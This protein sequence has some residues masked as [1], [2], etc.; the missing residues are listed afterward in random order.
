MSKVDF[1]TKAVLDAIEGFDEGTVKEFARTVEN[2][3]RLYAGDKAK[4]K[5]AFRELTLNKSI[6]FETKRKEVFLNA[7]KQNQVIADIEAR[8]PENPTPEQVG[9]ELT[10]VLAAN[11]IDM[12]GNVGRSVEA[13]AKAMAN[14]ISSYVLKRLDDIGA[15]EVLRS[16]KY[17]IDILKEMHAMTMKGYDGKSVTNNKIAFEIAK[18]FNTVD[19]M[20][21]RNYKD[22]GVFIRELEGRTIRQMHSREKMSAK[23]REAW[24]SYMDRAGVLDEQRVFSAEEL[25]DAN[26]KRKRLGE[27]YDNILSGKEE[28]S[29]I[30]AVDELL[31]K[32]SYGAIRGRVGKSRSIHFAD[33]E[34]MA[35]YLS[36]F[37]EDDLAKVVFQDIGSSSS[38]AAMAQ[39]FG[40]STKVTGLFSGG[41]NEG[42]IG[43]IK[44][45]LMK[46]YGMKEGHFSEFDKQARLLMGAMSPDDADTLVRGSSTAHAVVN[47]A[48]LSMAPITAGLTDPIFTATALT[49]TNSKSFFSNLASTIKQSVKTFAGDQKKAQA[50]L[51]KQLMFLESERGEI[52]RLAGV[53]GIDGTPGALAKMQEMFFKYSGFLRQTTSS[54]T[55]A[56]KQFVTDLFDF[57]GR[58]FKDLPNGYQTL[59]SKHGV[60]ADE[61]RL[62]AMG[63]DV[64]AWGDDII[65][66]EAISKLDDELFDSSPRVG[67]GKKRELIRKMHGAMY[68][69]LHQ[70]TPTP[71]NRERGALMLN[72][73]PN[74]LSSLAMG[75]VM[76]YKSFAFTS[77]NSVLASVKRASGKNSLQ[78][79]IKT[80]EGAILAAQ[81]FF[82][83][84]AMGYASLAIRDMLRNRE[85]RE[86]DTQ[87]AIESMVHGGGLGIYGDLLLRDYTGKF[88][89]SLGDVVAGPTIGSMNELAKVVQTFA[90]G[91][92]NKAGT[93]G[94]R[95]I[96]RHL[97]P[98]NNAPIIKPILDEMVVDGILRHS[99]PDYVRRLKNYYRREG[100]E[101]IIGD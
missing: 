54:K 70:A 83:L 11:S 48:K 29:A 21:L 18:T 89:G 4:L 17:N 63:K 24:I 28:I 80:N 25:V 15:E 75:H 35:K 41:L 61:W 68:E 51:R 101:P 20:K 47:M 49:S 3:N 57:S 12:R 76:K 96:Q 50:F 82:S 44:R 16:K 58:E 84:T 30:S 93:K 88:G 1:C 2:L 81:A 56:T 37:G 71:N 31:D 26:L 92:F 34:Q 42:S 22:S 13:R 8:L 85:P 10:N 53:Q 23:G 77:L 6:Y 100:M 79:A 86:F 74:A 90:K 98:A 67:A 14:E 59:L 55:T 46:K 66:M 73:D 78:E 5:K 99:D 45:V 64:D 38:R 39:V 62:V 94:I 40:S 95:F 33:P 19:K 72:Q 52:V 7:K 60:S 32:K 43:N 91:D 65:S 97:V 69:W 27:M 87:T 36:E 9:K